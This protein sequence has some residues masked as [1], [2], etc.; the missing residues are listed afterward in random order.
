MKISISVVPGRQYSKKIEKDA[1]NEDKEVIINLPME[2]RRMLKKEK[3][4]LKNN[5]KQ[6]QVRTLMNRVF[7]E[8]PDAK[9]VNNYQGALA[10]ENVNLMRYLANILRRKGLFFVD[11]ITSTKSKAYETMKKL[12]V[13]T[14]KRD[15]ILDSE[16]IPE[17]ILYQLE[18]LKQTSITEGKAIGIG[19]E[20][21]ITL[22]TL[23]K[24]LPK[25]EKKGFEFVFV[26]ELF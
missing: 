23:K 22:E 8:I 1:V 18:L 11:S 7:A 12:K 4:L 20:D 10:T 17:R 24:E 16:P 3:L 21:K 25:L 5:M 2:S 6:T 13:K 26:S 15:I 19:K 9:G 14:E